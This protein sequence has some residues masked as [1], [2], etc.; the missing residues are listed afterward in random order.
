MAVQCVVTV[1]MPFLSLQVSLFRDTINW[2]G[3]ALALLLNEQGHGHTTAIC[4]QS[5]KQ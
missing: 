2:L 3:L 1:A 4:S 5:S